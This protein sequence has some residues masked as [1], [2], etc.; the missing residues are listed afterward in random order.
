MNTRKA[1]ARM[2]AGRRAQGVSPAMR[3]KMGEVYRARQAKDRGLVEHRD[4]PTLN[5]LFVR[6][7]VHSVKV[8]GELYLWTHTA[9]GKT[10]VLEDQ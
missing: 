9:A 5:A 4:N 3:E 2:Q 6:G 7:L 8:S 10:F 1:I